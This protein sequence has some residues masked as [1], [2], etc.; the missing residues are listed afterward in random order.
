MNDHDLLISLNTKMSAACESINKIENAIFKQAENCKHRVEQC[1]QIHSSK[2]NT[3][4]VKW[5]VGIL[6]VFMVGL[7]GMTVDAQMSIVELQHIIGGLMVP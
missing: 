2:I 6:V 3:S 1:T 7:A 4:M 5:M